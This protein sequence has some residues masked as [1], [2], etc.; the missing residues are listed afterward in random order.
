MMMMR[1]CAHG[2]DQAV[3]VHAAAEIEAA[4]EE[5]EEHEYQ[6]HGCRWFGFHPVFHPVPD[7]FH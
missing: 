6:P 1:S 4:A 5:E 7:R 3:D 2:P